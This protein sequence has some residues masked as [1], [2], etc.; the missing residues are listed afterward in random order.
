L[1]AKIEKC[2]R[3]LKFVNDI[4]EAGFLLSKEHTYDVR[5]KKLLS[6][7]NKIVVQ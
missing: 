4:S 5:A 1:C 6:I 2:Q 7:F 3:D